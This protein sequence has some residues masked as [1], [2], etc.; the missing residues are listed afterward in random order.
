MIRRGASQVCALEIEEALLEHPD[1]LQAVVFPIPDPQFGEEVAAAVVLRSDAVALGADVQES[2]A[3][4]AVLK[5]FLEA[6]ISRRRIPRKIMV[7]DAIPR[8]G[9]RAMAKAL[10]FAAFAEPAAV[11]PIQ[12]SGFGRPIVV[13]GWSKKCGPLCAER[14]V[15]GMREPDLRHLELPHT[16]EH[17]A[18]ECIRTLMRVWPEGPY[19]LGGYGTSGLVALE[20]ARQLEE[21]GAQVGFVALFDCHLQVSPA[22]RLWQFLHKAILPGSHAASDSL[23]GDHQRPWSGR[24]LT[25]ASSETLTQEL[26]RV[27]LIHSSSPQ[28]CN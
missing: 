6:H 26:D 17:V 28:L 25:D 15:F 12:T 2:A 5:G 19:V 1:V 9:R 27:A 11:F 20:M 21:D 18:A 16:V 10:G 14:P 3:A 23:V 24:I 8:V 4:G 22:Q 7:I 13:L